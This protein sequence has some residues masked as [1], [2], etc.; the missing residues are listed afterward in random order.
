MPAPL[1][2]IIPT[3]N[4]EA[5]LPLCLESLMPGLEAGLIREVIVADG[6]SEDATAKIAGAMGA[7]LV[8]G[9]RG[10]GAQLS[11]GAAA[12]RGD[13][14]LFLHADTALSRDWAERTSDHIM[15][16]PDHAAFFELRYRSDARAARTLEKRANRRARM[17]GLPYGDQGLLIS[18]KLYDEV[19]GFLDVPLME[20]VMIVRAIGKQ[21]LTELNAEARTSA[22]K[23]ERDGW[24]KRSWRNAFLLIRFLLG[25]KPEDLAKRYT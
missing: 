6:G 20:D 25:A 13:W 3:L 9:A 17:L 2:I 10:R 4:A 1:S 16:K 5:E 19:G 23:Y 7:N 11:A 24:G 18:R 21:R 14:L 8:T 22:A 15:T 12:A